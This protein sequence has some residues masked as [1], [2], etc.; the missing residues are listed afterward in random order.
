MIV[1]DLGGCWFVLVVVGGGWV[2]YCSWAVRLWLHGF[3]SVCCCRFVLLCLSV[4]FR[5][6]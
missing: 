2:C 6:A 5:F 3:V 1:G 4:L